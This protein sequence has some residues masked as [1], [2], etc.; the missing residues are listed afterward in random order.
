M[1]NHEG[2][3]AQRSALLLAA[4]LG[5][6]GVAHMTAPRGFDRIVPRALPGNPRL[7]TYASGAA[8]LTVAAAVANP[9]TRRQGALAAA[10]L[11]TAILPANI[12]MALDWNERPAPLRVAAYARLPLQIPLVTWALGVRRRCVSLDTPQVA[13]GRRVR[14]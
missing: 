4:L 11:F 5:T 1:S 13:G 12:Q 9:R 2:D 3:H 14:R 10:C 8:E 6:A 7:W